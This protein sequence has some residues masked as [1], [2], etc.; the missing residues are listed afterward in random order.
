[1][2]LLP[3]TIDS[4]NPDQ[5]Q[6]FDLWSEAGYIRFYIQ[7]LDLFVFHHYF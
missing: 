5:K 1:M 6:M 7:T 3:N 4:N 2:H